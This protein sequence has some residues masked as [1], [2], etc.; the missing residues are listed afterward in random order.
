MVIRTDFRIVTGRRPDGSFDL[1]HQNVGGVRKVQKGELIL[2]E[3]VGGK[4]W[5]YRPVY[6]SWAGSLEPKWQ[7]GW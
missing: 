2:D 6:E 3:M 4:L 5:V 7:N 1:L